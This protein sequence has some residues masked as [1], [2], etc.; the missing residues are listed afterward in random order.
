MDVDRCKHAQGSE[1]G[2]HEDERPAGDWS[3]RF[4]FE[5]LDVGDF[6]NQKCMLGLEMV[7]LS[8]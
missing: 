3:N 2:D 4:F 8:Y 6:K 7:N 1:S 5:I